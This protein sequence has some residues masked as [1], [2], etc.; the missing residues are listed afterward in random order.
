MADSVGY[1]VEFVG[2]V[3][4]RDADGLLRLID[5]ADAD[6][7]RPVHWIP[8]EAAHDQGD[9]PT[10]LGPEWTPLGRVEESG[11]AALRAE[12]T[13]RRFTC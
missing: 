3:Y 8:D 7:T 9:E 13:A 10:E 2:P 12:E 5:G 4:Q 1:T 6:L 11:A